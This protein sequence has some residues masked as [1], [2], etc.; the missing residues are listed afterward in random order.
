VS[1]AHAP[2]AT[3]ATPFVRLGAV[4][5]VLPCAPRSR[6]RK[7]HAT[8]AAKVER[9]LLL[10]AFDDERPKQTRESPAA[11]DR[12]DIEPSDQ[13]RIT[14]NASQQFR[15]ELSEATPIDCR[16]VGLGRRFRFQFP[17]Q[18]RIGRKTDWLG[19]EVIPSLGSAFLDPFRRQGCISVGS[20]SGADAERTH[21]AGCKEGALYILATGNPLEVVKH[22]MFRG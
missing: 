19:F 20:I 2:T 3:R 17:L 4:R 9:P 6:R 21:F 12:D 10:K 14:S 5:V 22:L 1:V 8:A 11:L 13:R 18:I 7:G 16:A 15:W